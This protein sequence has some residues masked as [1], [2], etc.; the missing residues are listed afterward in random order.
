MVDIVDKA[1][2]SRMM[3]GMRSRHTKPEMTLRR[4]LHRAGYRYRLH[5]R[6]LP[7][8][9]DL[10]LPRFRAVILVHGCFW[11]RHDGCRFSTD[12]ATNADFWREKFARN[13]ERDRQNREQ[14]RSAGWRVGIVWE[15]ALRAHPARTV[16]DVI[17]WLERSDRHL[18]TKPA[19]T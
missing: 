8:R 13:V 5:A 7:G 14:L 17:D 3:A 10:V 11:H 16:G 1:T 4:G 2:R 15:C 9:P 18:E 6:D 12:P 19:T